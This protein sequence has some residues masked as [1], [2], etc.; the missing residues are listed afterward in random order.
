MQ[1][2]TWHRRSWTF[3]LGLECLPVSIARVCE[4]NRNFVSAD[5]NISFFTPIKYVSIP[6]LCLMLLWNLSFGFLSK[7][8]SSAFHVEIKSSM[9]VCLQ[10]L[11]NYDIAISISKQK[12]CVRSLTLVTQVS[13]PIE[14]NLHSSLSTCFATVLSDTWYR[15]FMRHDTEIC[16]YTL[17]GNIPH[18]LNVMILLVLAL[19]FKIKRQ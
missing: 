5:L 4:L 8:R 18:S 17:G 1:W 12:C 15:R 6:K 14:F 10:T 13:K 19:T 11:L 16:E 3:S 7:F 2:H 9:T